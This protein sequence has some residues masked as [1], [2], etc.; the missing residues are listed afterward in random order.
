MYDEDIRARGSTKKKR[1]RPKK[2]KTVEIE[3]KKE[4]LEEGYKAMA[5]E[6]KQFAKFSAEAA[7]E[8]LKV[9]VTE[10]VKNY[11]FTDYAKPKI[12]EITKPK[13]KKVIDNREKIYK[14]HGTWVG[15]DGYLQLPGVGR[16][17][18]GREIELSEKLAQALKKSPNWRIRTSFEYK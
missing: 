9:R 4:E 7:E 18:S 3:P 14:Y 16:I 11:N 10:E 15:P 8:A 13:V 1:G 17:F 5:E 6:H 12:K 2:V